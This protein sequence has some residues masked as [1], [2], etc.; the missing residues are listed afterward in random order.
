VVIRGL[1]HHPKV[2]V[3]GLVWAEALIPLHNRS[4]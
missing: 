4:S 2:D 1:L 3:A